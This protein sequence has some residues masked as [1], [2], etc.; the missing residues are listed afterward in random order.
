[1]KKNILLVGNGGRE[2]ALAWKLVQSPHIK[3]VYVVPPGNG[4]IEGIRVKNAV[5]LP[6]R[7][8]KDWV[9]FAKKFI[10]LT[11]VGPEQYLADGIGDEFRQEGLKIFG[12]TKNA[13]EVE[14]SKI[15]AKELMRKQ[16]IPTAAFA[17]FQNLEALHHICGA[18]LPLVIKADGPAGGK[19]TSI[20]HTRQEAEHTLH[21]LMVE[22]RHGGAGE[23]VVI[24]EFL[25]GPEISLHA[26]AHGMQFLL[27]PPSR[28]HKQLLADGKGPMTG[29]MGAY[30]PIPSLLHRWPLIKICEGIVARTLCGLE[31]NSTPF[32]GCLYPGLKL[33]PEGPKVLEFN[34]RFGDPETQVYMRLLK[35]DLFELLDGF[36]GG[37][38]PKKIEWHPGYAVCVVIASKDY[39]VAHPKE[40]IPIEGLARA[41]TLPDVVIFHAGTAYENGV[42]Y[43]TGGRVL[44]ITATGTTLEEASKKAYE[45][46]SYI[47]FNGMQFRTDIG[48]VII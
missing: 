43:A 39:P 11:I 19:G 9:P 14:N 3:R 20:C 4:G 28:D 6:L 16:N 30:A 36:A 10:D 34:A 37:I 25:E 13:A 40:K 46:V 23:K 35:S 12:P 24:E 33:T 15:F 41:S 8:P 45:A 2:H 5:N 42:F 27:F 21:Q 48:K 47:H 17:T 31:K 38:L 44:N 1:M 32:S 7:N 22:K 26:L 18:K 29:S